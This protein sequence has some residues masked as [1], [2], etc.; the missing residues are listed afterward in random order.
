M[1]T[2]SSIE[3]FEEFKKFRESIIEVELNLTGYNCQN[4]GNIF[5]DFAGLQNVLCDECI[6]DL[7]ND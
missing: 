6:D 3:D 2:K 4:C 7:P 5:F 1:P